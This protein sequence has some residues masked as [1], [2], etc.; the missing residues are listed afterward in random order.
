MGWSLDELG[1]RMT[2]ARKGVSLGNLERVP[3]F[4]RLVDLY[5]WAM[6]TEREMLSLLELG[7]ELSTQ[8][9]NYATS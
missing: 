6:A 3:Q 8:H 5:A 7:D 2:P 1:R 9:R 4:N